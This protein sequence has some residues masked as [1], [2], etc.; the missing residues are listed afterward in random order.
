MISYQREL[1]FS[2]YVPSSELGHFVTDQIS[3][4]LKHATE[5]AAVLTEVCRNLS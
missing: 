2:E 1:K 4:V 5:S 3:L